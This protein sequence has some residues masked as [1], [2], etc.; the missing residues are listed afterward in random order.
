MATLT[1]TTTPSTSLTPAPRQSVIGFPVSTLSFDQQV[2]CVVNWAKAG[3]S[4]VVCVAN[5][6]MLVEASWDPQLATVLHDADLVTPD[7][8]PLVWMVKLLSKMHQDRVA[9][10][11]L[12]LAVCQQAMDEGVS[13]YF[14]GS[15]ARTLEQMR[16]RLQH[17]FPRLKV[18]G[19][20]PL[21]L[22]TL[23]IEVDQNVIE[24][25][26]DS[27]AGVVFLSL[28]CPKQEKWM[29]AYYN[30][31][32]AV[33]L[34]VGGVFPIYAGQQLR[35]PEFIRAAGLEWLYRLV[36][37]PRRLWKRY[38]RTIPPFLWMAVKQVVQFKVRRRLAMLKP[39]VAPKLAG[40]DSAID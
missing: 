6:H 20:S 19:L 37:E 18:A 17:D 39:K 10:M 2:D 21:P 35:A 22:I 16:V 13:V 27:G 31:I 9:G 29:A 34:G 36:Q 24:M 23:P 25:I 38:S 7:G 32:T 1:T 8:M 5:V 40:P 26:N 15:D 33:M 14:L 12:M 28:G 30:K 11:D 3:L 4:K